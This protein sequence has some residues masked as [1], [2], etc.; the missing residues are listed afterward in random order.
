VVVVCALLGACA[1]GKG[2]QPTAID[3]APHEVAP[4][5]WFVVRLQKKGP[6]EVINRQQFTEYRS[7]GVKL[8]TGGSLERKPP[9]LLEA[10]APIRLKAG[11][12][13]TF[14]FEDTPIER[15]VIA[16]GNAEAFWTKPYLIHRREPNGS[17]S[18][19]QGSDLHLRGLA[20]G[21][22]TLEVEFANGLPR[23]VIPLEIGPA[24]KPVG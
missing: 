23:R 1:H 3:P 21:T 20:P 12:V 13:K 15:I 24:A 8:Y 14:L 2:Q 16:G 6:Q 11:Q 4:D 22:G 19:H 7:K 5:D 9:A 18:E 10:P 17:V